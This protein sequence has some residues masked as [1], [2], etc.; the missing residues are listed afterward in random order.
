MD[1]DK[2]AL[3]PG[4]ALLAID[5][6]NDFMPGGSLAVP[7]G[8][9]IVPVMNSY[10]NTFHSQRLAIFASR[11]WHPENHQS[12]ISQGGPWPPHCIAGTKGAEFH[13]QL[14]LSKEAI[15]ISK[16]MSPSDTGYSVFSN[17]EFNEIL[18]RQNIHR[19]F[20]GGLATDYC[21]LDGVTAALKHGYEVFLLEDA[22]RAVNVNIN[23]G[24]KAIKTML[25]K[26]AT[27]I[28]LKALQ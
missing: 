6:Q 14:R 9:E 7:L 19:L 3:I 10:I 4:D 20:V 1:A 15:V 26:G 17:P 11:D 24:D 12:F 23:D 22:V 13:P 18:Q 5:I 21:V 27:S 25:S 8:D 2:V 28:T 16:G